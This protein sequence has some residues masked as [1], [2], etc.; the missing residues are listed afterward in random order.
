MKIF[1]RFL[2]PLLVVFSFGSFFILSYPSISNFVNEYYNESNYQSFSKNSYTA[3]N[4][5]IQKMQREAQTYNEALYISYFENFDNSQYEQTLNSYNNILNYGNGLIGYIEIPKINI[6]IPIYHGGNEDVL[7]QGAA[8]L[9]G[10]SFPI[11]GNNTHSAI[12]A[13]SGYPAE[14]F[15]DDI[16]DLENSDLIYI[17]VLNQK[18]TYRVYATNIVEPSDTKA[19]E[20]AKDKD[21]LTLITCYPY[22]INTHRLLVHTERVESNSNSTSD[23]VNIISESKNINYIPLIINL[24]IFILLIAVLIA[25]KKKIINKL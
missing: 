16:D 15:F 13:H 24:V 9:E 1:K 8:H 11:G 5:E 2:F 20:I 10:T 18:L 3:S 4:E 22:G 14:K 19:L 12:S 7:T 17:Y 25:V 21:L 23:E 6:K